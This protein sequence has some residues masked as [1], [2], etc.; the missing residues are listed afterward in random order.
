MA[1]LPDPNPVDAG[2]LSRG[3]AVDHLGR[4]TIHCKACG[5]E[6]M[7]ERYKMILGGN[8]GF[9]APV[10]VKPFLHH[11]STKGKLGR[12]GIF[13]LCCKCFSLWPE[14]EGARQSLDAQGFDSDGVIP[15]HMH[16]EMLNRAAEEREKSQS[17]PESVGS[18]STSKVQKLD[19]E[20]PRTSKVRKLDAGAAPAPKP[21]KASGPEVVE[22]PEEPKGPKV[23]AEVV[24]EAAEAKTRRL[25]AKPEREPTD[26][27]VEEDPE[28]VA[29]R[30]KLAEAEREAQ[31]RMERRQAKE[32]A[33]KQ[34]VEKEKL[35]DS[36]TQE[37]TE[38]EAKLAELRDSAND[39]TS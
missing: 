5:N 27:A 9:G 18:S 36:L 33:E 11:C 25:G 17:E 32:E 35:V 12:K 31:W 3:G 24:E 8:F 6:Q 23:E 20:A 22:P 16:Y 37:L 29:L 26:P 15:E 4:A 34:R 1:N 28:V 21:P 10:F 30:E 38:A 39:D 19:A 13:A 2:Y 14:D 7:A